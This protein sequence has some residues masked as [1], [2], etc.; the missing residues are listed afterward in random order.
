[1]S[2]MAKSLFPACASFG[3]FFIAMGGFLPNRGGTPYGLIPGALGTAMTTT[4]LLI[5]Y[6]ALIKL[7]AESEPLSAGRQPGNSIS[8]TSEKS[9]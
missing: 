9:Q 4:A 1:M 5:I 8:A 2:K 6:R 7:D 3:P